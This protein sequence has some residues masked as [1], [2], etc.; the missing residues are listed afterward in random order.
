MAI[1]ACW[2]CFSNPYSNSNVITDIRFFITARKNFTRK[3]FKS[4]LAASIWFSVLWHR[5]EY[6]GRSYRVL[7]I[8]KV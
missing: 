3:R 1:G 8:K 6:A 2:S 7:G 5:R 4:L